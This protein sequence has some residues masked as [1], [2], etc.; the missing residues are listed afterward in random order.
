MTVYERIRNRRIELNFSQDE[1]A[2]RLGY[3]SRSSI[4]KI[5]LGK[6]D[7]TTIMLERIA[8]ALNTTPAYLMGWE[9]KPTKE[10]SPAPI[11]QTS[12]L[13]PDEQELLSDYR[14]LNNIGKDKAKEYISDLNENI[15]YTNSGAEAKDKIG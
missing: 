15:R 7:I 2:S 8:K 6:N 10:H 12:T 1:L 4:N 14:N 3:K 11:V 13:T 9:D 5:E